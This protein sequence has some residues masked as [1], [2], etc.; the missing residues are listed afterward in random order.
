MVGFVEREGGVLALFGSGF[1][2]L[3]VDEEHGHKLVVERH[4][5][6]V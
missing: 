1:L 6:R 2:G 3:F 5:L 4:K